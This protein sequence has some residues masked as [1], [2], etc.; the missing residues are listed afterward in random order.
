MQER[1][2]ISNSIS[3]NIT[4]KDLKKIFKSFYLKKIVFTLKF[5]ELFS[6][7]LAAKYAIKVFSTPM[8]KRARLKRELDLFKT[9]V[10]DEILFE[11]KV[12]KTYVFGENNSKQL[13]LIHG[14]EGQA[15]DFY[16]MIPALVEAGYKVITF[17]GPAHGSSEGKTTNM[18]IFS[19]AVKLIAEKFG[20]DFDAFIG[21][22]FG[23]GASL[24]ALTTYKDLNVKKVISLG[25]PDLI[26]KVFDDFYKLVD[27]PKNVQYKVVQILQER[28]GKKVSDL[29]LARMYAEYNKPSLVVHDFSDKIV[30][31][32]DAES[33][34]NKAP[35]V[36]LFQTNGLGH[37]RV[38]HDKLVHKEII[39]FLF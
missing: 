27:L 16:R 36:K 39:D 8:V 35:H 9:A 18:I 2:I 10:K 14:W 29:S 34:K 25:S 28:T 21:H 30:S 4:L 1:D 22:S 5:F 17:D 20:N 26:S 33:I 15:G 3:L 11:N 23:G 32:S 31:F 19:R 37:V 13:L 12:L 38:L 24:V 6:T 7:T